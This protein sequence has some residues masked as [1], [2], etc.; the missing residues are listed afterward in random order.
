MS[1]ACFELRLHRQ[2]STVVAELSCDSLAFGALHCPFTPALV[3]ALAS[4]R[5][6]LVLEFSLGIFEVPLF[7][8]FSP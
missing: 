3:K 6:D 5:C 1:V 8:L 4:L 2:P 7:A